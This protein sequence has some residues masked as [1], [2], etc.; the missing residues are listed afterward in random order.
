MSMKV[1]V[2]LWALDENEFGIVGLLV[3]DEIALPHKGRKRRNSC[4][5]AR[6]HGIFST[7]DVFDALSYIF[8][9]FHDKDW[10]NAAQ[11]L[12]YFERVFF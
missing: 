7:P 1:L 2:L 11:R 10:R 8:S 5:C 9:T 3:K 4:P 6:E 12:L